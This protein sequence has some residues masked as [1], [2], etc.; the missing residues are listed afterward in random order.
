M[1]TVLVTVS[2]SSGTSSLAQSVYCF[3]SA[4]FDPDV[5]AP[6]LHNFY[7]AWA[8]R[9]TATGGFRLEPDWRTVNTETGQTIALTPFDSGDVWTQ[10]TTGGGVRLPDATAVVVR[11]RSG[12]YVAGKPVNGR[13]FLPYGNTGNGE[14]GTSGAA[15]TAMNTAGAAL[16]SQAG[17]FVIWSRAHGVMKPVVTAST[18]SEYG[19]QRRRRD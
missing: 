19:V 3:D 9:A 12:E 1:A 14:G 13:S 18:W 8:A 6:A 5:V 11:W 4:T 2:G 7:I 17:S 10:A 15:Q 16:I